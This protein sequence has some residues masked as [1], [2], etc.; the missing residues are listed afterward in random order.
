LGFSKT[1]K[2]QGFHWKSL[3]LSIMSSLRGT[4]EP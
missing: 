4:N 1:L 3:D 2:M